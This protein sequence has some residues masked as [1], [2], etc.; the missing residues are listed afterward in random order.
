MPPLVLKLIAVALLSEL[1]V[2]SE[3]CLHHPLV[4]PILFL[5]LEYD[6]ATLWSSELIA[7]KNS[8]RHSGN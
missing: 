7:V 5:N 1:S 2:D 6:Y 8:S 4:L 3:A